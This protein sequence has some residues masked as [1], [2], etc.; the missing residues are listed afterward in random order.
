MDDGIL[1][2]AITA[3]NIRCSLRK[4][5]G[6]DLC[7]KHKN[8]IKFGRIDDANNYTNKDNFIKTT[9]EIIKGVEYL[10]DNNNIVYSYSTDLSK[11]KVIG[12]KINGI[13]QFI[14]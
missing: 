8:N 9:K 3:K 5:A 6:C 7:L 14:S 10:V 12:E 1:C 13:L 11:T 4:S 2:K